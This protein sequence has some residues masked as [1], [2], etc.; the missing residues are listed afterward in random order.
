MNNSALQKLPLKKKTAEILA[1]HMS[2]KELVSKAYI[3]L[4][5]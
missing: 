4:K 5:F 1:K 3:G 2:G